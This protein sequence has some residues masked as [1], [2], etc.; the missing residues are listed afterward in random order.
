[1]SEII[2]GKGRQPFAQKIGPVE[3]VVVEKQ[4]LLDE[5]INNE[6]QY[7][8][9]S[10]FLIETQKRQAVYERSQ[11]WATDYNSMFRDTRPQTKEDA[12]GEMRQEIGALQ[13]KVAFLEAEKR[14]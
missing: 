7:T 4:R 1:M 10:N 9:G 2:E 14:E 6:Q 13:K 5:Q 12:I 8:G 11:R 3:F